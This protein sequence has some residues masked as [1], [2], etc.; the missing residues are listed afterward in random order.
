V[1]NSVRIAP[2]FERMADHRRNLVRGQAGAGGPLPCRLPRPPH[3]RR[4]CATDWQTLTAERDA[5]STPALPAR[6]RHRLCAS[7]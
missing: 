6:A 1:A 2:F 4:A 7:G 5:T 3:T